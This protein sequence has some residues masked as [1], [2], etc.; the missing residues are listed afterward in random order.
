[1]LPRFFQLWIVKLMVLLEFVL[2]LKFQL[3]VVLL[4]GF[5][6]RIVFRFLVGLIGEFQYIPVI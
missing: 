3:L 4:V 1:M 6:Q 2:R 5:I